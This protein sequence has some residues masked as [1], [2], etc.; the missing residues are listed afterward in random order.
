MS[1]FLHQM[2][3]IIDLILNSGVDDD[4]RQKFVLASALFVVE[5]D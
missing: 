5:P 4:V 2:S 3:L 1:S